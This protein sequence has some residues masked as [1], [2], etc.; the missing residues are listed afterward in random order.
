MADVRTRDNLICPDYP[1]LVTVLSTG[2]GAE[3]CPQCMGVFR[4]KENTTFNWKPVW[5]NLVGNR[6]I[7]HRG[8]SK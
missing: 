5:E 3:K 4:M 7:L 6:Y 8:R 1:E 2:L